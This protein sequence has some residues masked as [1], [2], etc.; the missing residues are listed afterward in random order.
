MSNAYNEHMSVR[1]GP[2]TQVCVDKLGVFTKKSGHEQPKHD[3]FPTLTVGFLW[4]N[5]TRVHSFGMKTVN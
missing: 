2:W 1:T 5:L 3:L 4:L